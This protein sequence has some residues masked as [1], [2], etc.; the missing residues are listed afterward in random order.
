MQGERDVFR[1]AGGEFFQVFFGGMEQAC[2][3]AD[4]QVPV[5]VIQELRDAVVRQPVLRGDAREHT[6]LEAEQSA[7]KRA[8]PHAAI[9]VG[10]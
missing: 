4:P 5:A 2:I 8:D 1:S 10:Q 9:G 7:A 3:S 6:A